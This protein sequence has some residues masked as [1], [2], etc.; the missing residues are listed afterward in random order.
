[1]MHKQGTRQVQGAKLGLG[2]MQKQGTRQVQGAKQGQG[3][4]RTQGTRQVQGAEQG[5][6]MM[7]TQG[8]RQ[9]QGAKQGPGTNRA[10]RFELEENENKYLKCGLI[11]QSLSPVCLL[12]IIRHVH[13]DFL[14][15]FARFC[16]AFAVDW[17]SAICKAFFHQRFGEMLAVFVSLIVIVLTVLSYLAFGE[18][19]TNTFE[20]HGEKV[21]EIKEEREAPAIFMMSFVLPLLMDDLSSPQKWI[22][23]IAV[24]YIECRVLSKTNLYYKSPLLALL[25]YKVF[26]FQVANPDELYGLKKD[27]TYIGITKGKRI[28]KSRVIVWKYIADNVLLVYNR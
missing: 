4:M 18:V 3:M 9:V 21:I 22:S 6:G 23:Y 25:G 10:Q 20:N 14:A 28:D 27:E 2:M 16:D 19:Q 11:M 17:M 26:S 7:R 5:Q 13:G 24:V 1:M 12:L 15:L 8:T